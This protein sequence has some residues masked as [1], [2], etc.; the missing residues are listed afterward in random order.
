MQM[1]SKAA[2]ALTALVLVF[3]T[4]P[5]L[6][7][8]M[9]NRIGSH[10]L[11]AERWVPTVS[12]DRFA[13]MNDAASEKESFAASQL[14]LLQ[15]AFFCRSGVTGGM[16]VWIKLTEPGGK[17]I[18]INLEHVT[19]VRTATQVPGARAQLDLANGKFQGVQEAVEEVMQLISAA[20]GA[21]ESDGNT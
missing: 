8:D 9:P 1:L 21:R 7:A 14:A 2:A 18:H 10:G 15:R 20:S 13:A 6:L 19:S 4:A 16:A 5:R 17:L 12:N 11:S 3:G